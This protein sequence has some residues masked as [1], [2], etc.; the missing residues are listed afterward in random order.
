V[1]CGAFLAGGACALLGGDWP[2]AAGLGAAC[3]VIVPVLAVV[4]CD[5]AYLAVP[6][7]RRRVRRAAPRIRRRVR[8]AA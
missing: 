3:M 2:L 8:R 5:L 6:R 7:I 1:A 4:L